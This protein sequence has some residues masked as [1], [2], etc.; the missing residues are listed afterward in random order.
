MAIY[1]C[2]VK[3]IGRSAKR[4]SVSSSAHSAYVSGSVVAGVA[5]RSGEKMYN[6]YDD[7][8]HDYT[9][10]RG[11]VHAEI[12]LPE[13]A[14]PEFSDRQTL[15]N[16]VETKD[17]RKDSQLAREC[18]VALPCEF[19]LD[20]QKEVVREYISDNFINSGMCADFAIHDKGDGNPHAHIML[21]MRDVSA[22]GFGKRMKEEQGQS[23]EN[24]VKRLKGWR[25]SWAVTCNEKLQKKGTNERIDYRTLEAQ[26]IGRIPTKH[27]GK[28]AHNLEKQGI[29]TYKGNENRKIIDLNKER[30]KRT[31]RERLERE[32]D[33]AATAKA[34]QE[35]QAEAI[36]V[37]H[38][39][40][41]EISRLQDSLKKLDTQYANIANKINYLMESN[42]H[43]W[44]EQRR[45]LY[46]TKNKLDKLTD[47]RTRITFIERQISDLLHEHANTG[48][49][50]ISQRKQITADIEKLKSEKIRIENYIEKTYDIDIKNLSDLS[51]SL[52]YD[53]EKVYKNIKDSKIIVNGQEIFK[54]VYG[55]EIGKLRKQGNEIAKEYNE[56]REQLE[57]LDPQQKQPIQQPERA[58]EQVRKRENVRTR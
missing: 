37:E 27:L 4:K 30:E 2:H 22:D 25:K 12:M 14:P 18:E 43:Y 44:K 17:R 33:V 16:A 5:Y 55:L 57:M 50:K 15:W 28:E 10:K 7:K 24:R 54:N 20:E 53:Y 51:I 8:V 34:E 47:Y 35:R 31:E 46:Q 3:I 36:K 52:S 39:R 40:K 1:H 13:N 6:G 32:K 19:S 38:A 56:Q 26:G 48:T 21:T 9:Y 11:V 29:K 23:Y 58:Y 49:F 41:Y 42:K 45:T